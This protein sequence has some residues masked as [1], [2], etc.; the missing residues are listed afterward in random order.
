MTD[1]LLQKLEEKVTTLLVE[2]ETL[3]K[4]VGVAKHENQALKAEHQNSSKKL[5]GLI[6][7]LDTMDIV[8]EPATHF[9]AEKEE[10]F[11]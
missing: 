6:S 10:A 3:R 1:N 2:L 5:Q 4:E 11:A 7:L 8:G 9:V